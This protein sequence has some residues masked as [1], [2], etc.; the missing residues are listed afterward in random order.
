MNNVLTFIVCRLVKQGYLLKNAIFW[1]VTLCGPFKNR[2]FGV[3]ACIIRVHIIFI[4]SVGR[5]LDTAN[6]PS[7]PSLVT[8]MMVVLRFSETS[9]LTRVTWRKIPEDGILHS[10][11]REKIKS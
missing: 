1:D 11:R 9:L 4:R 10:Y 2:R 8:V 7:S 3:T 6:I 5:L